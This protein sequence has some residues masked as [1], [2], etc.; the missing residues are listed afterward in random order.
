MSAQTVLMPPVVNALGYPKKNLRQAIINA[1][2]LIP[3]FLIGGFWGGAFGVALASALVAPVI[4]GLRLQLTLS[5][6]KMPVGPYLRCILPPLAST[7]AMAAFVLLVRQLPIQNPLVGLALQCGVGAVVYAA[8][9]SV[10]LWKQG[11]LGAIL[12]TAKNT[13]RGR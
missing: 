1:A 5:L 9:G 10:W 12:A 2:L 3:A 8:C 13:L 11:R 7:L 4:L 6:L